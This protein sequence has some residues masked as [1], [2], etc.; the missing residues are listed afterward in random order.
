L[1]IGTLLFGQDLVQLDGQA[2]VRVTYH[3]VVVDPGFGH[4]AFEVA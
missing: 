4:E 3:V 2:Q 1:G